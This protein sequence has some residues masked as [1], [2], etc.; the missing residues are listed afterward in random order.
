MLTSPLVNVR[1]APSVSDVGRAS[2]AN[3]PP[4]NASHA[5]ARNN[6]P[7]VG[8][9]VGVITPTHRSAASERF[10]DVVLPHLD[11]AY[12]LGARPTL[13][14]VQRDPATVAS[15]DVVTVTLPVMDG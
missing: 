6:R 1:A 13:A 10:E 9:Y 5:V 7:G 12:R 15:V 11:A 2:L 14:E 8:H 3:F 4:V